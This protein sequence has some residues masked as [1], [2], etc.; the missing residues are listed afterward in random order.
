[1]VPPEFTLTP[2]TPQLVLE[3]LMRRQRVKEVCAVCGRRQ[4][5]VALSVFRDIAWLCPLHDT[6]ARGIIPLPA[7]VEE[8]RSLFPARVTDARRSRSSRAA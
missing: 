8:L 3:V 6:V 4:G 5:Q 1:M 7:T 2:F